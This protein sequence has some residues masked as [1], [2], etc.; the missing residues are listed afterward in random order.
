MTCPDQGAD[1]GLLHLRYRTRSR[2]PHISNEADRT[3]YMPASL[4]VSILDLVVIGVVLISA[5]LAAVRGFTREV[6]AIVAWVTAAAV[7]WFL[8]P[9][10]LPQLKNHISNPT[11]ALAAAI[12]AI[13]V[14]TLLIVSIITVKFSDFVLDSRIGALDR[15]L[16]FVFG[17]ARGFLICVIGWVFLA[18]LVQGKMPDWAST[19]RSRPM[20]ESTGSTLIAMLPDPEGVMA[21]LRKRQPEDVAQPPADTTPPRVTAPA[22]SRS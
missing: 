9:L 22:P 15:T 20:L 12:G 3:S 8:H 17:A 19:A 5:L 11:L 1:D 21:Q 2:A 18:W 16:G 7:A 14:V 4:P 13:F 6:L 10:L